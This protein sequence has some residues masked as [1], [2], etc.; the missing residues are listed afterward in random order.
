[1][2]CHFNTYRVD[3]YPGE[4]GDV[5]PLF[6]DVVYI[7]HDDNVHQVLSPYMSCPQGL[8]EVGQADHR[9]RLVSQQT[10]DDVMD[11]MVVSDSILVLLGN[12]MGYF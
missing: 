3:V 11:K 2:L 4:A 6:D 12:N 9:R 10:K 1:M 5:G 7:S 8:D